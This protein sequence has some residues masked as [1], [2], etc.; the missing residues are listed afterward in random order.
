[1]T[2]TSKI[3]IPGKAAMLQPG[4]SISE[5]VV[6]GHRLGAAVLGPFWAIGVSW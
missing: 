1:V 2:G 4:I 3:V 6:A 5:G